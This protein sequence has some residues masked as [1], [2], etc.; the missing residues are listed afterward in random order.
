MRSFPMLAMFEGHVHLRQGDMLEVVRETMA[1]SKY[2]VV[3]PNTSPPLLGYLDC[4]SYW[5]EVRAAVEKAKAAGYPCVDGFV[6]LITMYVNED[7]TPRMI[8]KAKEAGIVAG[9]LYPK[10]RTTGSDYGIS[11]YERLT[12]ALRAMEECDLVCCLHGEHPDPHP[13]A[14]VLDWEAEFVTKIYDRLVRGFPRLRVVLEHITTKRA[15][16]AVKA[17]ARNRPAAVAATITA[18]HL[19]QTID[20]VLAFGIQPHNYCKPVSKRPRDLVA[21]RQ[22]ASSGS[23]LFFLGSDSAPHPIDGKE[24]ACGC[25]GCFTAAYLP[26]HLAEFFQDCC[27]SFGWYDQ[28]PGEAGAVPSLFEK[29]SA[30]NGAA[31][32]GF[33]KQ[34]YGKPNWKDRV[35]L[36]CSTVQHIPEFFDYGGNRVRHWRAGEA[37]SWKLTDV[38]T[39]GVERD[40][41][42]GQH[43]N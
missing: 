40:Q 28:D 23:P 22:A 35:Q 17:A 15:V 11:D 18:H 32:Y 3:M 5:N 30:V 39:A 42:V 34:P 4:L 10:G 21:L 41:G 2:A 37:L 27:G 6:P 29:F 24:S 19:F 1:Y 16:E 31:F 26:G 8:R 7:T 43:A 20:D 38:R 13:S 25:A 12:P 36:E 9:K 14:T 33:A